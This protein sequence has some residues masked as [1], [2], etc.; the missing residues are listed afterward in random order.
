LQMPV[1]TSKSGLGEPITE[2][3]VPSASDACSIPAG[4]VG[5]AASM[6]IYAR[7]HATTTFEIV[8]DR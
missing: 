6:F 8:S 3:G 7:P 1:T 2:A 4:Y 5:G